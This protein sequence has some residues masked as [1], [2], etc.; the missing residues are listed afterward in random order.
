MNRLT[1]GKQIGAAS[2]VLVGLTIVLAVA[3]LVSINA[4]SGKIGSLRDDSIPGQY[5][6]GT[7]DASVSRWRVTMNAELLDLAVNGGRDALRRQAAVD[8]AYGRLQRQI[9][10]YEKTINNTEDRQNFQPVVPAAERCLQSWTRVRDTARGGANTEQVLALYRAETAPAFE[11]LD[12][13]VTRV[14]DWN[15]AAAKAYAGAAS[16]EA[17]QAQRWN[18]TVA[19]VSVIIGALLAW[20][21][22]RGINRALRRSVHD[23]AEGAEHVAAAAAQVAGAAQALAQGSSEQAASLEETSASSEEINSM[24]RKN[25]ENTASAATLVT[26]AQRRFEETNQALEQTVRAMADIHAQSGKIS[27]I[28]QTIEEIAFQTNIL[29]LNAAV[30]AA[31][32]GDAGMGFAVVADEVRSLAQRCAQAAKDT[33]SLIEESIAKSNEG[34]TRVDQVAASIRS[35]TGDSA[36]TKTL[37][38]EVNLTSQEQAHGIDQI[39]KAI[40]QMEEVTQKNAASAEESASPAEELSAQ[41]QNLKDIVE[42]L[43]A[44]VGGGGGAASSGAVT[45]AARGR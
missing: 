35:V 36:K 4:L 12:A 34:K 41:S 30:E 3:S 13:A 44:L 16:A 18:W 39:G 9:Q 23:L 38:D 45:A 11:A 25:T 2:A 40:R 32:A 22:A 28:I 8:A 26:S 10:E 19:L 17:L 27:K 37:V 1:I 6:S 43:T 31:R 33:S 29:A 24:S 15:Q 21:L 14:V 7:V 42:R 5:L 20:F